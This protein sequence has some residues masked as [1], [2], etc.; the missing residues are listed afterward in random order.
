MLSRLLVRRF[1]GPS[2]WSCGVCGSSSCRVMPAGGCGGPPSRL[3]GGAWV[4]CR[5][6]SAVRWVRFPSLVPVAQV[7]PLCG[8]FSGEPASAPRVQASAS[9]E[10]TIGPHTVNPRTGEILATAKPSRFHRALDLLYGPPAHSIPPRPGQFGG[11]LQLTGFKAFAFELVSLTLIVTCLL[12]ALNIIPIIP[13]DTS[14]VHTNVS[15]DAYWDQY[16]HE[17]DSEKGGN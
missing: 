5:S 13:A 17:L 11:R 10:V 3:V 12:C 1:S 14:A 8:V 4:F 2:P 16:W 9:P 7:L 15:A 6:C